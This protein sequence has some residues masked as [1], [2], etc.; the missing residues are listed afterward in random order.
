MSAH[1]IARPTMLGRER[2]VIH[3]EAVRSK[4]NAALPATPAQVRLLKITPWF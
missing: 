1:E 3:P 2:I 4:I